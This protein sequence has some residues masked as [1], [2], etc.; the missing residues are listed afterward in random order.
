MSAASRA[1]KATGAN[2]SSRTPPAT[3]ASGWRG[4]GGPYRSDSSLPCAALD[5]FSVFA[6]P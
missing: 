1:M 3:F 2:S 6:L 5:G 4:A